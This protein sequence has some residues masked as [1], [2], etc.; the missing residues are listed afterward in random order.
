MSLPRWLLGLGA[1]QWCTPC[2]FWLLG[3]VQPSSGT[4]CGPVGLRQVPFCVLCFAET[5][6]VA[7]SP[8]VLWSNLWVL[9]C[10]RISLWASWFDVPLA[11]DRTPGVSR[12]FEDAASITSETGCLSGCSLGGRTYSQSLGIWFLSGMRL[13]V[14]RFSLIRWQ[15]LLLF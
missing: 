12:H 6:P 1:A 4:H 11:G 13:E 10:L 3:I 2:P 7:V 9:K 15:R 8:G 14:G 5:L